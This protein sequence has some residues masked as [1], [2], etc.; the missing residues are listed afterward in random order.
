MTDGWLNPQGDEVHISFFGLQR[1]PK[2]RNAV[3]AQQDAGGCPVTPN[4]TT[5]SSSSRNTLNPLLYV[6]CLFSLPFSQKSYLR[7]KPGIHE[8][9][10]IFLLSVSLFPTWSPDSTHHFKGLQRKKK[11]KRLTATVILSVC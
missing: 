3:S 5:S 8:C 7:H 1:T 11:R 9:D 2:S 6:H 4:I 10:Y